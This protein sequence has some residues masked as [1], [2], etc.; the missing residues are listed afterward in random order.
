MTMPMTGAA[1][2]HRRPGRSAAA[3]L[4]A[5]FA[6]VFLSL[7]TDQVLHVLQVYPPWGEPMH[8]PGLNLL[9]LSYRLVFGVLGGYI[10]ARLAPDRPMRHALILGAVGTV[11][12]LLGVVAAST[13]D[14]G[15][16]WYPISLVVT[17]LPCSWLGGT[18]HLARRS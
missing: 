3:L 8:E 2:P 13:R 11:L 9:A 14:L 4:A 7:G 6:T 16:M 10:A 12:S 15:P 18:L 5:F 1:P 17:A